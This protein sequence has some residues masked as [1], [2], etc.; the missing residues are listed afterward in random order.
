MINNSNQRF[1]NA[2]LKDTALKVSRASEFPKSE[3]AFTDK[4]TLK[5]YN[6]ETPLYNIDFKAILDNPQ[7]AEA[8]KV[9]FIKDALAD[10]SRDAFKYIHSSRISFWNTSKQAKEL[11]DNYF[12]NKQYEKSEDPN[13][14][15]KYFEFRTKS[16]YPETPQLITEYFANRST[17]AAKYPYELEL[18]I[19]LKL[20]GKEEEAVKYLEIVVDDVIHDRLGKYVNYGERNPSLTDGNVFEHL[21]LCDNESVAKKA[22]DLLF[23]LV[24]Q[25]KMEGKQTQFFELLEYVDKNRYHQVLDKWYAFYMNLDFSK[26]DTNVLKEHG[27]SKVIAQFP[28]VAGYDW[29]VSFY[30]EYLAEKYGKKFWNDFISKAKIAQYGN[31]DIANSQLY[32][33]ENI[34]KNKTVTNEDLKQ[35]LFQVIKTPKLFQ[36]DNKARYLRLICKAYPDRKIPK[37]DFDKLQLEKIY[38][39]SMPLALNE[40]DLELPQYWE[41]PTVAKI[42]KLAADINEFSRE[43]NL[44][45][46]SFNKKQTFL[47]SRL[48]APDADVIICDH[49]IKNNLIIEVDYNNNEE[50]AFSNYIDLYN[51]AF[52]KVLEK[53]NYH[54][55]ISQITQK[56]KEDEYRYQVYVKYNNTIYKTEYTGKEKPY[57][58]GRRLMKMINLCL[59]EHKAKERIIEIKVNKLNHTFAFIEPGRLTPFLDKQSN[60]QKKIYYWATGSEDEFTN[61]NRR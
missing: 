36:S 22:T 4:V 59:I 6:S 20:M 12:H 56:I 24:F 32:K 34:S 8:D 42:N 55:T 58:N 40:E 61:V 48:A 25:K 18:I 33:L 43:N 35:M 30:S 49:L 47:L 26:I 2:I 3:I 51:S 41:I 27:W 57:Q 54:F 29:F 39:Y 53:K 31:D 21:C 19:Q 7:Y 52:R 44:N 13:T 46:I 60:K 14:R 5:A 28:D 16:F 37:A 50:I 11:I 23:N 45:A 17:V 38:A 10:T 9:K 15:Y 1:D